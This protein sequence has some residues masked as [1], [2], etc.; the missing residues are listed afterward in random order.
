MLKNIANLNQKQIQSTVVPLLFNSVSFIIYPVLELTSYTNLFTD[1][2]LNTHAS[3]YGEN[4]NPDYYLLLSDLSQLYDDLYVINRQLHLAYEDLM[5]YF[6][7]ELRV[8]FLRSYMATNGFTDDL[9]QSPDYLS[10]LETF[11]AIFGDFLD[12]YNAYR[13]AIITI[14]TYL[15]QIL[16]INPNFRFSLPSFNPIRVTPIEWLIINFTQPNFV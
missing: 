13:N 9:E 8:D 11:N 4:F 12:R 14:H 5:E 16:A 6:S 7:S 1:V 10:R 2:F 15:Q 3:L